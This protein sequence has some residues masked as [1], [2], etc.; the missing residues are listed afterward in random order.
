MSHF[1]VMLATATAC[2][3]AVRGTRG[4]WTGVRGVYVGQ[5]E[6]V[7]LTLKGRITRKMERT[8]VLDC[9]VEAPDHLELGPNCLRV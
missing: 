3:A 7:K 1:P 9:V 5:G 4:G 2:F 6:W 8:W